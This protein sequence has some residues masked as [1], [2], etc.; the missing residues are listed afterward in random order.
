M[1]EKNKMGIAAIFAIV[2]QKKPRKCWE[3]IIGMTSGGF[4]ETTRRL[5]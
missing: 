4:P 1:R 2:A 3:T 5:T